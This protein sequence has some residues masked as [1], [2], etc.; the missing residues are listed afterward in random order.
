[1]LEVKDTTSI[2]LNENK[3]AVKLAAQITAGNIL[4]D[5]ATKIVTPHL[6][7]MA[8][9][10]AQTDIG[11]AVI[12][13]VVAGAIVHF[14]PT[15]EKAVMASQAMINS[16]ML[17]LAGSFNFEDMVN[18]FLDGISPDVLKGVVDTESEAE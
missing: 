8:K 4:V 15:N 2:V 3:S 1:M 14:L 5:R 6:P 9:G 16:A 10:Y 17:K 18:E 13:N 7:L 11:Q 12:A